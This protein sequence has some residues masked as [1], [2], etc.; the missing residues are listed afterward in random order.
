MTKSLGQI[1]MEKFG[2]NIYHPSWETQADSIKLRW[3]EASLTVIEESQK[4]ALKEIP[5]DELP[6]TRVCVEFS[7][8][9]CA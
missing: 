3:E 9:T 7:S 4:R 2:E 6:S 8:L 5:K 1:A